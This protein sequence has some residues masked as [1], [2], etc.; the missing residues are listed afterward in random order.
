MPAFIPRSDDQCLAWS[1]NYV[2]RINA[3][4]AKYRISEDEASELARLQ[5][6]FAETLYLVKS[7]QTRTAMTI[8]QKVSTRRA[9]ERVARRV[10]QKA[11]A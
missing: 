5:A 10:W 3:N 4:P 9:M 1:A 6:E 7:P 11:A 2:R 8:G